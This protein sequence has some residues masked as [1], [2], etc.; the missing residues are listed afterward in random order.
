[1][2]IIS[3]VTTK[4]SMDKA[5][6][7]IILFFLASCANHT[8]TKNSVYFAGE[9]VNPITDYVVLFKDE[10]VVDSAKIDA[11]NRFSFSLNNI[12]EGLHHFR[13]EPELQYVYLENGDSL[14]IRLNTLAFD[15]SL[16]FS[17][18]NEEVNNF[19]LEMFLNYEDEDQL[20]YSYYELSPEEFSKKI[21]SLRLQKIEELNELRT[22]K[23]ISATAFKMAEAS[24]NYN[25][26]TY[27]E[28]YPF[29]HKK[30]LGE[31][32]ILQL[33][34]SF[35][36]Y[37]EGLVINNKEL[38]YFRPYYNYVNNRFG[39]ISYMA[40]AQNCGVEELMSSKDYL[41]L[42]KHKMKLIDSLVKEDRLRNN[43]FRNVVMDYL[44]RV[45][46]ATNECDDFIT[47]FSELSDNEEHVNE[48]N[49]LYKGIK[50]LQPKQAIPEVIV[51]NTAGKDISL[52]TIS[53]NKKTFFY[54]WTGNQKRHFRNVTRHIKKLQNTHPQYN[55][56]GINLRTSEEKWLSMITDH[57]IDKKNQYRSE[58]FE[59]IQESLIIN[60]LNKSII[61][62][63]TVIV[64]AFENVFNKTP[65]IEKQKTLT[66]R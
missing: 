43:L 65:L 13:H 56:V 60:T 48:I 21:D 26:Y 45:H 19:L 50:S 51:Q 58:D 59:N 4:L 54:F 44:L 40:C 39:N 16:V 53:K 5:L 8:E 14:V 57:S 31:K 20:V 29:I 3:F 52:K 22:S 41:H 61:T 38:T 34:P 12:E 33:D 18:S 15:E 64:D 11:N 62:N 9:I 25:S 10:T 36:D 66:S 32:T 2:C 47:S 7:Y 55:Y 24:V 6:P 49:H 28:K 63:D 23:D 30:R 27:K 1:M 37:R 46:E 17:G 42:N 35:Y